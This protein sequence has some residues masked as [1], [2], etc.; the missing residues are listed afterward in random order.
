MVLPLVPVTSTTVRP[1]ASRASIRRSS[2]VATRPPMTEPCRPARRATPPTTRAA[3]AA[4]RARSGS[5]A[6]P[7]EITSDDAAPSPG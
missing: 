2:T 7:S 1:A 3:V 4:I 5:R 6:A